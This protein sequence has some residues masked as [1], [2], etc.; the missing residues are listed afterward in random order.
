MYRLF[1]S[2][3][4]FPAL[5]YF[6]IFA[7]RCLI[8][9]GN[10]G[11]LS[12]PNIIMLQHALLGDNSFNMGAV[13]AKRLALNRTKGPIFGGIYASRLSRHFRIPIRHY[14]KGETILPSYILDYR[15]MVAH[16]FIIQNEDKTLLYNLRFNKKHNETIILH[17]PLLFDLIADNFLVTPEAVYAHRG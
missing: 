10:S 15:S 9:R 16:N 11:N 5:R 7:S 1:P 12:V 8:G 3:V 2:S 17:A 14:E 13:V 6:A 4:H